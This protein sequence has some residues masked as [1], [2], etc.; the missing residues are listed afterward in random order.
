[1]KGG[2]KMKWNQRCTAVD[3]RDLS[4]PVAT[5]YVAWNGE[6]ARA[7][8]GTFPSREEA[9]KMVWV[10]T[11]YHTPPTRLPRVTEWRV[12][13]SE[14]GN[15]IILFPEFRWKESM[16]AG[17]PFSSRE[18][19]RG[20]SRYLPVSIPIVVDGKL[21][22]ETLTRPSWNKARLALLAYY[23]KYAKIE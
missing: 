16:V 18:W 14:A 17:V 22:S 9:E 2:E 21:E 3:R 12:A 19:P 11:Q 8:F 20:D 6:P 15:P 7:F 4:K 5:F 10:D 13:L 23:H 1:M